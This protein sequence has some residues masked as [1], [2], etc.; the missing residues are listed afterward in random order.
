MGNL[1]FLASYPKS[2]NTWTRAFLHNLL[3][4]P[5]KP[6][7]INELD[8]WS[9]GGDRADLYQK[10]TSKKVTDLT[11]LEVAQIRPKVQ[12]YLTTVHPDSVF[13]KTHNMFGYVRGCP[14]IDP[15]V[16]AGAI[17]IVR[18][19]LDVAISTAHHFGMTVN[20][21]I[22]YLNR[23]GAQTNTNEKSVNQVFGSWSQHVASWTQ[24]PSP[25]VHVMR[26]EDMVETPVET[27][28]KLA[29]FLGLRPPPERLEKAIR[30]S[31]FDQLKAQEDA[32]GFREKSEYTR[33]FREGKIG[34][35]RERLTDKQA[36]KIIRHHRDQMKRFGYI[37]KGY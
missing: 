9:V 20:G 10:F 11:P 32:E 8:K 12:A 31:S 25:Q 3:R 33:F 5:D 26:Y 34:Q 37:P 36:R 21:A 7:N 30:F 18:N 23:N 29:N 13:V 14:L 15:K 2:G 27:F 4:N 24:V 6:V 28:A 17:Y 19:P 35:W 16:T 22:E 1:I